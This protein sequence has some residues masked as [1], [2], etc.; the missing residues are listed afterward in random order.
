VNRFC[1]SFRDLAQTGITLLISG[2]H[3]RRVLKIAGKA[4]ILED[5]KI[6]RSGTGQDLLEDR[7]LQEILFIH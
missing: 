3:I 5:G 7:H 2:Q 6:V 4:F 1:H